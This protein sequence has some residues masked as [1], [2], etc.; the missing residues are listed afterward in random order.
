MAGFEQVVE[1]LALGFLEQ[2]QSDPPEII[3]GNGVDLHAP[4]LEKIQRDV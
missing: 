2:A 1:T 3:S 4:N